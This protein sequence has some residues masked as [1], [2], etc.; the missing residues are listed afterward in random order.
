MTTNVTVTIGRNIGNEPMGERTW[1]AFQDTVQTAL[2]HAD[3]GKRPTFL[4]S[5]TGQG[6]WQGVSEQ[7]VIFSASYDGA[8]IDRDALSSL[9]GRIAKVFKQ[10]AVAL[11]IGELTFPG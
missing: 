4:A 3:A 10:D 7:S 11:S 9:L 2:Q 5:Y 1:R 6:E 8:T